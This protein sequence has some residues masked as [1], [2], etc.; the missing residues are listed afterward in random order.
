MKMLD[1]LYQIDKSVF[2]PSPLWKFK[3]GIYSKYGM[4]LKSGSTPPPGTLY[5]WNLTTLNIGL[6][7]DYS[8]LTDFDLNG[9]DAGKAQ[10][11]GGTGGYLYVYGNQTIENKIFTYTKYLRAPEGGTVFKNCLFRPT[12]LQSGMY[13]VELVGGTM[14]DC[15]VSGELLNE[16]WAHNCLSLTNSILRRNN[17]H[18]CDAGV[19]AYNTNGQTIISQNYIHDVLYKVDSNDHCVGMSIWS[20]EGDGVIVSNNRILMDDELVRVHCTGAFFNQPA[21]GYV[22][23]NGVSVT[24]NLF[25][26]S[27]YVIH[28]TGTTGTTLPYSITNNRLT[29]LPSDSAWGYFAT[30]TIT[31]EWS[32]NYVYDENDPDGKGTLITI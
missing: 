11:I 3:K 16:D 12:A 30:N 18:H 8:A 13:F 28:L 31:P 15:E 29:L 7:G 1:K 14:E 5:G 26:S 27:S 21:S 24:G 17:L 23:T 19:M 10:W 20:S 4:F 25:E 2:P 32:E 22:I 9:A 6:K